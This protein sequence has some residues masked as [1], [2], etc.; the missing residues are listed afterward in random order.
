MM[1]RKIVLSAFAKAQTETPGN[2]KTQWADHLANSLWCECNYQISRRTLLNYY[3]S[4]LEDGGDEEL[5]PNAKM[6]E[7][8]CKYLGYPNY[9]TFLLHQASIQSVENNEYPQA[10]TYTLQTESYKEEVTILVRR[11]LVAPRNVA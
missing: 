10:F 7:M 2:T 8:L 5:S 6:I 11:E 1:F 9:G 3:N 4:Y